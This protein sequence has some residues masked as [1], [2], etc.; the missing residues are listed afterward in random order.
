MEMKNTMMQLSLSFFFFK[1]FEDEVASST[2]RD[3][4]K[5][6]DGERVGK[7]DASSAHQKQHE[8][9][10]VISGSPQ[11]AASLIQW[12]HSPEE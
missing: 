10:F 8:L 11:Y 7:T 3:R 2:M 6:Y 9:G 12:K 1:C 4:M 5:E